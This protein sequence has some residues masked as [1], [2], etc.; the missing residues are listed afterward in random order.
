[1]SA[2]LG[3]LLQRFLDLV[4]AEVPLAG[5]RGFADALDTERLRD[6][7]EGDVGGS[8]PDR[9][10]AAAIRCAWSEAARLVGDGPPNRLTS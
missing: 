9:C 8:R 2:V 4:L 6:R 1:M 7:D 3:D 10:A 5:R